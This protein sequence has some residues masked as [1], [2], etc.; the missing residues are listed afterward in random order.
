MSDGNVGT[1]M[2]CFLINVGQTDP[3][4]GVPIIKNVCVFWGIRTKYP[5]LPDPG[6]DL[7]IEGVD[8]KLLRELELLDAIYSLS[9][10]LSPAARKE[11]RTAVAVGVK[12]IEGKLPSDVS[13]AST[14]PSRASSR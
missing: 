9:G 7:V 8:P 14:Y 12:R 13:L 4:R 3:R 6:P 1:A 2:R 11:V 10:R 5:V